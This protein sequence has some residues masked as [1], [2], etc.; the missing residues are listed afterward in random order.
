MA[1][2]KAVILDWA[3]TTVDFGSLAPVRTIQEVFRRRGL[4]VSEALARRDMGIAKRDHIR[5]VLA[6]FEPDVTEAVVD[7]LYAAF[8]PLQLQVLNENSELIPG[9]RDAV[10]RM[11]ARGLRIGSTT[12]YTR[13]MLEVLM[14]CAQ[15]Q[16]Y[17]PEVSLTPE[18]VGGGR[19]HPFMIFE[20]AVRLKTYPLSA[21][22]KI[23]DTPSD[24]EEG[25]NA[26]C[27]TVGVAATGNMMGLCGTIE[28]ACDELRRAGAH[29]VIDSVADT[30]AVFDE[31]ENRLSAGRLP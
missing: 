28:R 30:D 12:G 27:W 10:E 13:Q 3:G 14:R 1:R 18:D 7:E 22:V 31:I 26:G 6:T 11:K 4:A 21:F 16:G 15:A 9:V 23:G 29:F 5:A 19:P 8:V 25:R 24:I 20:A 17:E 2:L